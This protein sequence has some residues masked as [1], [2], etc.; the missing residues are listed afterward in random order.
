MA[1]I[2]TVFESTVLVET[3]LR[4]YFITSYHQSNHRPL[5]AS[6]HDIQ[7]LCEDMATCALV[8]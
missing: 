4:P 2:R 5:E 7:M 3:L 6:L 8:P 1:S